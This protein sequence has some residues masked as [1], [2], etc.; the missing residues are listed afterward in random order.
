MFKKHLL[1]SQVTYFQHLYWAI[2]AGFRL[3]WA[4][5][6]SIIHGFV[7]TLL[8]GRAPKTV[9]DIYHNHLLGH[10]NGEYKEMIKQAKEKNK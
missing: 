10:P 2:L 1:K 3:I 9:I 7:P 6:A 4:G 5:I 8:D